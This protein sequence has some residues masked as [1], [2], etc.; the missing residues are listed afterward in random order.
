MADLNLVPHAYIFY[1]FRPQELHYTSC[2]LW[3]RSK[4]LA[5]E[6]YKEVKRNKSTDS[7]GEKPV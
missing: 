4:L 3:I 6:K 5:V 2:C 7:I 1:N